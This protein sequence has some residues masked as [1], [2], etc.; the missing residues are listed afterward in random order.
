MRASRDE[1]VWMT[2][3]ARLP[4]VEWEIS[5][6]VQHGGDG[7]EGS[8][9][10]TIAVRSIPWGGQCENEARLVGHHAGPRSRHL[11]QVATALEVMG[12]SGRREPGVGLSFQHSADGVPAKLRSR[13][14]TRRRFG[15]DEV[16]LP[17]R[18]NWAALIEA[19]GSST[20][21]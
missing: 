15:D 16:A 13:R 21:N 10:Q 5:K 3:A 6:A 8:R 2:Y 11:Y 20:S 9:R 14:P 17:S 19:P 12:D 4:R 7:F 18:I 1:A